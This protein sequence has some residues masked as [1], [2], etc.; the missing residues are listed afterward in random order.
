M[1]K[2]VQY[3]AWAES[4][5]S[6]KH[7]ELTKQRLELAPAPK[8]SHHYDFASFAFFHLLIKGDYDDEVD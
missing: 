4:A 8:K 1:Q 3:S 2:V 7:L 6:V 5:T